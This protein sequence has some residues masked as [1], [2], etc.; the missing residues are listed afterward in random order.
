MS[1]PFQ[2]IDP[3][4]RAYALSNAWLDRLWTG[5]MWCE[6]PVYFAD[7]DFL[8]WSDIPNDR[9]LQWTEGSGARVFRQPASN[10]N[11]Q[12]RDR[13]GRLI[14]CEHRARRVTR[15]EYDGTVTVLADTFQG[16]RLNSPNDVVVA[17]D[18]GVWFTD[19]PYGIRT[20]YEG[21]RS[22]QEQDGCY[23]FRLDPDSG[24]LTAVVTDG[25]CPNGLAFSPDEATLYVSDTGVADDDP[26]QPH[27]RVFD[28]GADGTLSAGRPFARLDAGKSD[29]FRF[30]TDG[31]L[32]TSAGDGVHCLAPDGTLIGKIAVPE[33]VSN[34]AFGGPKRNRLFITATRSLYAIYV[35]ANGALRP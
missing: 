12:T 2:V 26:D 18:D 31:N 28:V 14:C 32:W 3:R 8:L 9:I 13:Q 27:I 22:D 17:S 4:F 23:V 10:T 21:D 11:G 6:G 1:S 25:I 34:V 33:K 29:G 5:G 24:D 30:D 15:T 35:G 16:R 20:D 7:G 19:P